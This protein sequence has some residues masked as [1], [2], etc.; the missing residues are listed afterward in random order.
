MLD[1]KR[2]GVA[3]FL[4][5]QFAEVLRSLGDGTAIFGTVPTGRRGAVRF[6][7]MICFFVGMSSGRGLRG[8]REFYRPPPESSVA[9]AYFLH[10]RKDDGGEGER[11]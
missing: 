5:L 6:R 9:D 2:G 11:N 3:N 8:E 10:E 7:R 4:R 1:A